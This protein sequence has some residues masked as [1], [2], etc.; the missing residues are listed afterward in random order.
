VLD[1]DRLDAA[2]LDRLADRIMVALSGLVAAP[3]ARP[4][5]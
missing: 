1:T 4:A 5:D 2:A 3:I